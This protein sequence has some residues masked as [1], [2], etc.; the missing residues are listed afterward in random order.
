MAY[1]ILHRSTVDPDIGD[2]LRKH[3]KQPYFLP[4]RSSL[5]DIAWIFMGAPGP[6]ADM[7]VSLY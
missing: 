6:G 1:H 7:H 4:P 3:V 2:E 5:T